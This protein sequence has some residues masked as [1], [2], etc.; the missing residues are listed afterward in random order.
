MT[1]HNPLVYY[2]NDLC[3]ESNT[4]D[5]DAP[6]AYMNVNENNSTITIANK[7]Q[8]ITKRYNYQNPDETPKLENPTQTKEKMMITITF[9]NMHFKKSDCEQL[10]YYMTISSYDYKPMLKVWGS[11]KDEKADDWIKTFNS[12]D[13][14]EKEN[15]LKKLE[16]LKKVHQMYY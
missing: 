8:K 14:K 15:M 4:A 13:L 9:F 2:L 5:E 7:E 1:Y 16:L 12:A 11:Y 6:I 3:L 10:V